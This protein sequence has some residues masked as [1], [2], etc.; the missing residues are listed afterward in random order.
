VLN[1]RYF[2][3]GAACLSLGACS[4]FETL[5]GSFAYAPGVGNRLVVTGEPYKVPIVNLD[6][7]PVQFHRQIVN[8]PT[9]EAPGTI[10]VDPGQRFLYLVEANGK[11]RR[12]GIGV[13]RE[14]FAWSGSATIQMKREWPKWFPPVEMQARDERA[15]KFADGM[16]GGPDNPLG[17]RAMY[18]FQN[19]KDT[20]YRI[21][22]TNEPLSIGK[23]VSSGCVRML[24]AD[25]I[26]L[27]S[28]VPIGTKVVVLSA[29][30]PI[31]RL[32]EALTD[33]DAKWRQNVRRL[34]GQPPA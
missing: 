25:V 23:A 8:D 18:L 20:L 32:G 11:A 3:A 15:K 29:E 21:H 27:Y 5:G 6:S 33:P 9:G 28:R 22:G 2:L 34:A 12:Y 24:N 14:G 4:T 30:G 16:D 17:A 13:G 7:I 26:D 1:R 10:V 31:A 19:G